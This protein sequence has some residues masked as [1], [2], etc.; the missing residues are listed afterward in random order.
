MADPQKK[1][2]A[3]KEFYADPSQISDND[4]TQ[5]LTNGV[6]VEVGQLTANWVNGSNAYTYFASII[7][8]VTAR[9]PPRPIQ[10]L[11]DSVT[12]DGMGNVQAKWSDYE[13]IQN[14]QICRVEQ[15]DGTNWTTTDTMINV[16]ADDS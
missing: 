13:V 6:A 7:S 3:K 1:T 14:G 8:F 11:A 12:V 15:F 4:G 5:D 16:I 9:V 10:T 2:D